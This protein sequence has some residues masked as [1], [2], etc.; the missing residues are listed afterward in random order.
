MVSIDPRSRDAVLSLD[1]H[2]ASP[3]GTQTLIRSHRTSVRSTRAL[4]VCQLRHSIDA[5]PLRGFSSRQARGGV[6]SADKLAEIDWPYYRMPPNPGPPFWLARFRPWCEDKI[7]HCAVRGVLLAEDAP[8]PLHPPCFRTVLAGPT[9]HSQNRLG[10]R[11]CADTAGDFENHAPSTN[12]LAAT[13]S[14]RC[15]YCQTEYS[16]S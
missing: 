5:V 8:G 7:A 4:F 6:P 16:Y 15:V 10:M 1:V 9:G 2:D 13:V 14:F 12:D 11:D 3:S